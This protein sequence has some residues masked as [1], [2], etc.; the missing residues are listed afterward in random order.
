MSIHDTTVPADSPLSPS[1][2]DLLW[3][4][5]RAADEAAFRVLV[6][7]HVDFVYSAARRR[8]GGD[9]ASAAD[10]AQQVFTALARQAARLPASI[11]LP[12]W[13]YTT[14]RHLSANLVRAEQSRRAR[15]RVAHFMQDV[16]AEPS[17][18]EA[19]EGVRPV[20]D[21]EIDALADRDRSALLLRFFA[22]RS[23]AEIGTQLDVSEDA[24]RMRVERALEKLRAALAKREVVSTATALGGLLTRNGVTAAPPALGASIAGAAFLAGSGAGIFVFMTSTKFLLGVTAAAI[25][26]GAIGFASLTPSGSSVESTKPSARAASSGPVAPERVA[27]SS[28]SDDK[29]QQMSVLSQPAPRPTP[30]PL[31]AADIGTRTVERRVERLDEL[32]RLTAEQKAQAAALFAKEYNVLEQIP[33]AD[34]GEKGRDAR[35]AT[36]KDVRD[37]LTPDQRRKYDVSPQAVGGGLPVDPASMVARLDESVALSPE[38]KRQAAEILWADIIEQVAALPEERTLNGFLWSDGVRDRLRAILTPEQRIRF[39]QTPP[40]R[41]NR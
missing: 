2:G 24:A 6:E 16:N 19:W 18:E 11:I 39:D 20:L 3:R 1:D 4:Y 13:L 32:V 22:R 27:R 9:G 25:A 12:A 36:R 30:S 7:R 5:V 26:A 10:V 21:A 29:T 31:P 40:Y 35:L 33:V 17:A 8:L 37:V 41:K 23:Y 38:Q 15:E 14:T 28:R 34:R